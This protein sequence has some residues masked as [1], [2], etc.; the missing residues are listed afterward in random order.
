LAI[1]PDA[2]PTWK[3]RR[4]HLLPRAD[5]RERA[6]AFDVE[7]DL[8]R[9]LIRPDFHLCVHGCMMRGSAAGST[10]HVFACAL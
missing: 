1:V 7:I 9:L 8:K 10:A 6:I 2:P 5:L 4:S 3:K